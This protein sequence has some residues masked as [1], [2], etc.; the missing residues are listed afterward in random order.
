MKIRIVLSTL[1]TSF[2]LAANLSAQQP[3]F[4]WARQMGGN[5]DDR[6]MSVSTDVHG[7]IYTTGFFTKTADFGTGPGTVSLTSNGDTDVFVQKLDADGNSLWVKQ[8]GGNSM[9]KGMSIT[10]DAFGNVYTI[11][12]FFETVDFDPGTGVANLISIGKYDVFI[13]KLDDNG[14]FIWVK[15]WSGTNNVWGRSI[16]TDAEGNIFIT[17][18]FQD[19]I[20][21]GSGVGSANLTSAGGNDVFIQKLDTEGNSLWVNQMGGTGY[22][23]VHCISV[24]TKGNVYTTGNFYGTVDFGPGSGV[25]NLTSTGDLNWFAQKHDSNGKLIWAKQSEGPGSC[26]GNSIATDIAGNVY[27]TGNFWGTVDFDP[28]PETA[29]LTSAGRFDAFVQKLDAN[30]NLIWVKQLGGAKDDEVGKSITTDA[31]GNVYT[32]GNFVGVVDFDPGAGTNNLTAKG[33]FTDI[34]IQKLDTDG[35]FIWVTQTGGAGIDNG[36]SITIDVQGNVIATGDFRETV[37]FDPGDGTTNLTSHRGD[38]IFVLKLSQT[39]V[40]ITENTFTENIQVYPNPTSGNFAIK[41]E[42]IQKDLSVRI[43]SISGQSL[44][45]RTF[46][47]TDFVQLKLEQPGGIYLVE[48]LNEKGKSAGFRLIKR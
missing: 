48:V 17:G 20:D 10:T 2:L 45:T 15:Q 16:A 37:D 39:T 9:D 41:F 29:N 12:S 42:T 38:D 33:Y 4:E 19:R 28:G 18:Y 11:G 5:G 3:T 1:F 43:M 46:R 14:N 6:A 21:F 24:D 13:Q 23:E 22:E 34:F 8:M 32:I 47:N 40:G 7:N 27:T 31:A 30:G 36:Q 25:A 35:N 44:E 26:S